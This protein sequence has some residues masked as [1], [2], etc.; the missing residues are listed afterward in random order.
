MNHQ[1]RIKI[2]GITRLEDAQAALALGADALGLVFVKKSPRYIDPP[3]ARAIL[4]QLPPFVTVVG[5]FMDH[6]AADVAAILRSVPLN[7]LQF[8]GDE[9]AEFCENFELP[10]IKAI[11][12]GA[13]VDP[14]AYAALHPAAKAFLLDSHGGGK[15]GGSGTTFDWAAIP[16]DFPRP[17]ILAGG[18]DANNVESAITT[19]RP[20]AVDI[21]SGVEAAKG[22]KDAGKMAAFI[23]AVRKGDRINAN[24]T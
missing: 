9:P 16:R 18:L 2:C 6:T 5:L 4:E 3:Q 14:L 13:G 8:H 24:P 7:L 15:S 23:A 20:Y 21:S 22:I 11:P 1:T 12:M 17:L 10:Y 19:I